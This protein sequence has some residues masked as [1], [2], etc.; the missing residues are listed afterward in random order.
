MYVMSTYIDST[1]QSSFLYALQASKIVSQICEP[2]SSLGIGGFGYFK[3][4]LD[5]SYLHI[6]NGLLN[7]QQ[8]YLEK[9]T[10][11]GTFQK[12]FQEI[13]PFQNRSFIIQNSL[14]FINEPIMHIAHMNSIT[15]G[16]DYYFRNEDHIELI[17]FVNISTKSFLDP[18]FLQSK[19][20]DLCL[21]KFIT[22]FKHKAGSILNCRDRSKLSFYKN[23]VD[24]SYNPNLQKNNSF[25]DFY[26]KMGNHLNVIK[27][28]NGI[29]ALTNRELRVLKMIHKN[30]KEIAS[31][32]NISK[33]TVEV[34]ID[35]IKIKT[36][37]LSKSALVD[38][39]LTNNLI[40]I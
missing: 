23:K 26:D 35:H 18:E 38:L 11:L 29:T 40:M 8:S 13:P 33:R 14:D 10:S 39:S 15:Q 16:I 5:N 28:E 24:I 7:F 32:L 27:S 30:T 34:Y 1:N 21:R 25:S 22:Y 36:G 17:Y 9:V 20:L 2:L 31:K 3:I 4:F 37:L 12:R 6:T 19:D